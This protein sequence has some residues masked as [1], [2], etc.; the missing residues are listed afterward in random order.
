M[1]LKQASRLTLNNKN[2]VVCWDAACN[3][4][5]P[6]WKGCLGKNGFG[7]VPSPVLKLFLGT[8]TATLAPPRIQMSKHSKHF[9]W[10][11]TM[12]RKKEKGSIFQWHFVAASCNSNLCGLF[13]H[14][15]NFHT[16]NFCMTVI[17]DISICH[18]FELS[19]L[20]YCPSQTKPKPPG[21]QI[22]QES[23]LHTCLQSDPVEVKS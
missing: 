9:G 8:F 22:Q 3:K 14:T 5:I 20:Q 15:T 23:Q 18:D 10:Y 2:N 4:Q 1:T 21:R 7:K 13:I 6:I 12:Q 11:G 16:W 17:S 19:A